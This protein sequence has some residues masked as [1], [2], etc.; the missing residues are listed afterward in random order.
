[1][2]NLNFPLFIT[3]SITSNCNLRC[4]HCFRDEYNCNELTKDKIDELVELLISKKVNR[5]ILTGGEPLTSKNLLYIAEKLAG[6]IKI[7]IATNGTL[8]TESLITKLKKYKIKDYQISLDG[9]TEYFNDS[10]RGEG[11]YKKVLK[12]INLLK[13]HKCNITLA[14]TVNSL[15]YDD[16]YNHSIS[17]AKNLEIKKMRIEYYIPI[18]KNNQ[19]KTISI[20]KMMRLEQKLTE[21][22]GDIKLQLPSIN[23]TYGCGAGIYNCVINSDLS[24]SPCDLLTHKYRTK[25]LENINLFQKYWLEDSTFIEWRKKMS[26]L[27]CKNQYKCLALEDYKNE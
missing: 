15:N 6:K 12:S 8:L 23:Q 16:I 18:N 10:I 27:S 22:K 4:K 25:I 21:E 14:M 24:I 20:D 9:A 17:L 1:M 7:G 26:C 2:D 19:L 13:K 11:I 3:W 5:I